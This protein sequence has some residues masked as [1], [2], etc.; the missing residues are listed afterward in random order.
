MS[1]GDQPMLRVGMDEVSDVAL[2]KLVAAKIMRKLRPKGTKRLQDV[3]EMYCAFNQRGPRRQ[4]VSKLSSSKFSKLTLECGLIGDGITRA[5][6]DCAYMQVK[7][8]NKSAIIFDEFKSA[9]EVLAAKVAQ[10]TGKHL[11]MA[12]YDLV[13]CFRAYLRLDVRR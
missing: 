13:L 3:F 2:D 12:Y 10:N 9:V 7:S 6:A 1:P 4:K 8:P 11:D 5:A